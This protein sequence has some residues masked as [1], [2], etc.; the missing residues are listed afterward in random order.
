MLGGHARGDLSV[1]LMSAR[2]AACPHLGGPVTCADSTPSRFVYSGCLVVHRVR[3]LFETPMYGRACR[4]RTVCVAPCWSC[5]AET[6]C[7]RT[8]CWVCMRVDAM[9]QTGRPVVHRARTEWWACHAGQAALP[10]TPCCGH[11]RIGGSRRRRG[12]HIHIGCEP[13]RTRRNESKVSRV[14]PDRSHSS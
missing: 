8:E 1:I 7:R 14:R 4:L 10:M 12:R 3:T 2:A 6:H 13:T 5:F 11:V 9:P